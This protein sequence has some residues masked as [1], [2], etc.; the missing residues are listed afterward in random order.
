MRLMLVIT[1][2]IL[3][4]PTSIPMFS[5]LDTLKVVPYS[6]PVVIFP[7]EEHRRPLASTKLYC[8]VRE[9]YVCVQL[10]RVV[11]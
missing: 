11:T 10:A 2:T 9:A 3:A 8:L 4:L 7:V 5:T 6:R 1:H